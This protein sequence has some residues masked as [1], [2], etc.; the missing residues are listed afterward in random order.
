MFSLCTWRVLGSFV[1]HWSAYLE[2][3][4]LLIRSS[5]ERISRSQPSTYLSA[6]EFLTSHCC[7]PKKRL[8]CRKG[9]QERSNMALV[10]S[11]TSR[12]HWNGSMRG[13]RVS[14]RF[15]E[16]NPN[17]MVSLITSLMRRTTQRRVS[18]HVWER[19]P[20]TAVARAGVLGASEGY[21]E[22]SRGQE[23]APRVH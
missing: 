21:C 18:Q 8:W 1:P 23:G 11:K 22:L 16:L 9:S 17:A 4:F 6:I 12:A 10:P 15:G 5:E 2:L 13:R 19:W 3:Q 14:L 7:C 20:T